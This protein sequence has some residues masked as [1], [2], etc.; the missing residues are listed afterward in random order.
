MR[1]VLVLDDSEALR[2]TLAVFLEEA[3]YQVTEAGSVAQAREALAAGSFELLLFDLQLPDGLGTEL[4]AD[5][6]RLHPAAK[7]IILSGSDS[8]DG[9]GADLVL[10]KGGSPAEIVRRFDSL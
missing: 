2:S 4:I 5:A 9:R 6:R 3:G 10:T 8:V 7:V 1:R